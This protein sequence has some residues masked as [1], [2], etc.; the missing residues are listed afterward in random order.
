VLKLYDY[1]ESGN[2]YKVRLLLHQLGIPFE[3]IECD[4]LKGETR[5]PEFLARNPNGRIPLL[6]LEDG[7][8]LAESNAIQWYLA[9]GT[10]LVP[11][12]RRGQ[13]EVLQWMGFEQYSHE[14]FIA[15]LRFWHFAGQLS[16]HAPEEIATKVAGGEAA[17]DVMARHLAER[18]F[19]V[20]G[21]YSIA[22]IA[23]YAYTHVA[24]EAGFRLERWPAVSAW[25][26]RVRSQPGHVPITC[27]EG[28]PG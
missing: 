1:H 7:G 5:T 3:R 28:L 20:G 11:S 26:A 23:L 18:D 22:D 21:A 15:V 19:F 2:G 16:Q 10:P 17:L 4:I 14:P 8:Y 24:E 6:E 13:A 25:L 9:S 12:G 27:L